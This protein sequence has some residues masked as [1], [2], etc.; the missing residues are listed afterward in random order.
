MHLDLAVSLG[1]IESLIEHPASMTH[2]ELSPADRKKA[3]IN[4]SLIRL[5]VKLENIEDIIADLKQALG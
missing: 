1:A 5:S 3:N 4:E 2:S